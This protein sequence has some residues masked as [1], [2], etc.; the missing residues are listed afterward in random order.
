MFKEVDTVHERNSSFTQDIPGF[1]IA[2]DS[3]SLGS[4]KTCPRLYYYEI[5]RGLQ[6]KAKPL[7]L[8]YGIHYH[9]ALECFDK[10]LAQGTGHED[11]VRGAVRYCLRLE[12]NLY[13]G[14]INEDEY[15]YLERDTGDTT[16]NREN[17][18][19][20]IIWY[21]EQF[22]NDPAKTIIL[23]N[24][25]PAVELTFKMEIPI[26]APNGDNML[27]CGHMDRVVKFA[28][29]TYVMDHKTTG[30]QVN[31]KYWKQYSPNNQVSLYTL[32]STVVLGE[33]AKGVI[34]ST[35]QLLVNSCRFARQQIHRT[36]A[37][38]HEWLD[39]VQRWI[40]MAQVYAEQNYW[41]MNEASC[42][43]F[44]GCDFRGV[45]GIDPSM[46]ER[47]LQ[48][49]FRERVWDPLKSR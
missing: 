19:R 34:I 35:C 5:I 13:E 7:P 46:R 25:K 27:L 43:N 10:L 4:L 28:G 42:Y 45:C 3:T 14:D 41:P 1:Q 20:S 26:F 31:E 30:S 11:A 48:S 9:A 8:I 15:R 21:L 16:R 29:N 32:A 39:E 24:G 2:W 22:R 33:T 47:V 36:A 38:T 6:P 40:G 17:L 18:T 44:G 23:K 12:G 49:D 37:Q